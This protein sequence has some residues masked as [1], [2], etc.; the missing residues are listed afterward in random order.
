MLEK[1]HSLSLAYLTS[2]N[3]AEH[4]RRGNDT[5]IHNYTELPRPRINQLVI[6]TGATRWSYC[7]LLAND[8]I[9]AEIDRL[10]DYGKLSLNL[11]FSAQLTNRQEAEHAVLL[12]VM[13]LPARRIT[14]ESDVTDTDSLWII[15]VVDE[16]YKWQF[17]HVGDLSAQVDFEQE[18]AANDLVDLLGEMTGTPFLNTKVNP[19]HSLLPSCVRSNDYENLP[20]VL[21]SVLAH[22]GQRLVVDIAGYD[23][24]TGDYGEPIGGSLLGSTRFAVIDGLNSK[25]AY[26]NNLD[27]FVGLR[28]C[29]WG[30]GGAIYTT[31]SASGLVV[32]G[33]PFIVAGGQHTTYGSEAIK[34]AT[35]P[36]SVDIQLTDGNFL[37]MT[38]E[39]TYET[40]TATAIWRTKFDTEPDESAKFQ[41]ARDYY[42][43]FFLQF[44]FTF[45]GVQPWQQGYND[46]YMVIRQTWNPRIHT[47]DA[48]TRVCS[49]Q[50]NLTG[51]WTK[52]ANRRFEAVLSEALDAPGSSLAEA[53]S[54]S[55]Y[56]LAPNEGALEVQP[57]L[58]EVFNP[59]P[60]LTG[61]RGTYCRVERIN[62]QLKIYYLGC[63]SQPAL[64][65]AMEA[66]EE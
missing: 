59:D 3:A 51:E 63:E 6:P 65:T 42:L 30:I 29:D 57:G 5:I 45:A 52:E 37:N 50:P 33:K 13:V 27:G 43:Q 62:G 39:G 22:Y 44:D 2:P 20:I 10:S 1:Y 46:D 36:S 58:H 48:Y 53:T 66:L 21:D 61:T 31:S 11:I 17:L 54:A 14:P 18:T 15:P 23:E 28:E 56:F 12:T 64:V 19:S 34:H 35:V 9:K 4:A 55:V 24:E 16:R 32:V 49:R 40:F 38:P 7:I 41:L 60:S 8:A 25:I 26:N 47:Y